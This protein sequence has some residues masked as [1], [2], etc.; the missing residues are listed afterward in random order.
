MFGREFVS[1]DR[2][3]FQQFGSP[4]YVRSIVRPVKLKKKGGLS[5]V[6]LLTS[7]LKYFIKLIAGHNVTNMS[8]NC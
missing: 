6:K 7:P 8:I 4:R 2:I 1:H 5:Q 3:V